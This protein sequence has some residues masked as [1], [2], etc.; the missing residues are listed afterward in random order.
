MI[1]KTRNDAGHPTGREISRDEADSILDL[2]PVTAK[3]PMPRWICL[4]TK[5]FPQKNILPYIG[6]VFH[7]HN[8]R[9][10]GRAKASR[11]HPLCALE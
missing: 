6:L 2:F 8:G 7:F 11:L 3:L 10:A 9:L 4:S 1:R 5:P